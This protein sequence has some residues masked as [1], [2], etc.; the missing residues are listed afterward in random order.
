[1]KPL[2]TA[3]KAWLGLKIFRFG[4]RWMWKGFWMAGAL[5]AAKGAVKGARRG[6]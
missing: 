6:A 2:R 4:A 5:A 1:M 3:F